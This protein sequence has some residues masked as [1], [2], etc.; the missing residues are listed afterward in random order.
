MRPESKGAMRSSMNGIEAE[1]AA[2]D[3]GQVDVLDRVI[4]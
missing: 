4:R 2:E 1:S 3:I